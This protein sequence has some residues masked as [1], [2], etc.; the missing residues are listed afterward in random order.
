MQQAVRLRRRVRELERKTQSQAHLIAH[1]KNQLATRIAKPIVP[2]LILPAVT[3][4][5]QVDFKEVQHLFQFSKA[6]G[7]TCLPDDYLHQ[8]LK[9]DEKVPRFKLEVLAPGLLHGAAVL[10][11][12]GTVAA[13]L[14]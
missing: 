4:A 6:H 9:R 8:I 12:V 5:V 2:A 11:L 14:F 7:C 13:N 3:H 10:T 1:L